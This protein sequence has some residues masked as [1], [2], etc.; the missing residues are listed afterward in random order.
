[1]NKYVVMIHDTDEDAWEAMSEEEHQVVYDCDREFVRL[2][3]ERGGAVTGG[4]ELTHSREARVR[5]RDQAV[6]EG[7]FAETT[8]VLSGFYLVD[9]PTTEALLE[10]TAVLGRVHDVVEVRPRINYDE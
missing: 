1:M 2:L 4:A 10:A 9:A 8:E 6:T 7:P 3:E 5:R